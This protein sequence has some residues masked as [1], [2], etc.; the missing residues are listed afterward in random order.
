MTEQKKPLV[1]NED[2]IFPADILG[3]VSHHIKTCEYM[4]HTYI[5]V[6]VYEVVFIEANAHLSYWYDMFDLLN[7]PTTTED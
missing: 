4:M 2:F 5:D 6:I 1:L 3:F 7:A